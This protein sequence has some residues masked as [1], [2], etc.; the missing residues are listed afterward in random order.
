M[1]VAHLRTLYRRSG[2]LLSAIADAAFGGSL[3]QNNPLCHS[4]NERRGAQPGL[5]RL[6][7]FIDLTRH[8]RLAG[9]PGFL[10]RQDPK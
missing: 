3:I 9:A 5:K 2:E 4:E 10:L 7:K 1:W 8:N 6:H